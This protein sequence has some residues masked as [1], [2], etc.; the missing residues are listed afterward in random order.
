MG[1]GTDEPITPSNGGGG[2]G[3]PPPKDCAGGKCRQS[4]IEHVVVLLQENHSFDNYFGRYC[5]APTGSNPACEEGPSC[6]EAG[7]DLEPAG[8]APVVLDDTANFAWDPP[9]YASCELDEIHGG[10]MDGFVTDPTCG[11]PG[12]FAYATDD[13]A[14]YWKLASE[15]ALADRYFQPVVGASSSNDMYLAAAGYVF[16]D[17]VYAPDAIGHTCTDPGGERTRSVEGASLGALLAQDGV[18]WKVYAGGYDAMKAA[19]DAGTCPAIPA[20]CPAQV[21]GYPCTYDPSDDPFAYYAAFADRPEHFADVDALH[22]DLAAGE[23]PEVVFV[24]SIGYLSEHP[25]SSLV[26]GVAFAEGLAREILAS[27]VGTRTL[28]LLTWDES[29]GYFDHVAPPPTS[30]DGEPYGARVPLVALGP[31]ARKNAVSHVVMEH[32]SIVRFIEWNWLGGETG[33]LGRRDVVVNDLRSLL[34]ATTL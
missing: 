33:Q 4:K 9:H 14:P 5:K 6:C 23:L 26:D 16:P 2:A 24:R 27:P 12:N 22:A 20:A 15:G 18:T 1:C 21:E 34:D 10:L 32:S 29:G 13:V 11:A 17:N 31:F 8:H 28:V 3:L 30:V 25:G 19:V 7:P